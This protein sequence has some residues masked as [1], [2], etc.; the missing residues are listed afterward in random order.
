MPSYDLTLPGAGVVVRAPP[1]TLWLR[2]GAQSSRLGVS[3]PTLFLS[4]RDRFRAGDLA[5]FAAGKSEDGNHIL[6]ASTFF[7]EFETVRECLPT[8]MDGNEMRKALQ[9]EI[10]RNVFDQAALW[11]R[12]FGGTTFVLHVKGT[13]QPNTPALPEFLHCAA[14]IPPSFLANHPE[15]HA[16][17]AQIAQIF[18][19]SV[20]VPTV[21]DWT[22]RALARGWSLSMG[23]QTPA[24]NV[25]VSTLIPNPRTPGSAHLKFMGRAVGEL[26][27]ILHP[28]VIMIP[29]DDDDDYFDSA[30]HN[31]F[32]LADQLRCMQSLAEDRRQQIDVLEQRQAVLRARVATLESEVRQ[33]RAQYQIPTQPQSPS[34]ARTPATTA[35][36][37][38]PL[39]TNRSSAAPF[40][41]VRS[42]APPPYSA[43]SPL[44][45]RP[46]SSLAHR[47]TPTHAPLVDNSEVSALILQHGLQHL[48]A[49]VNLIQR[50]TQ[51]VH[52]YEELLQLGIQAGV[53]SELVAAMNTEDHV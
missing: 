38:S 51:P 52:W 53:A 17:I 25:N 5:W 48:T 44:S 20:G 21:Q 11:D 31:T 6:T 7:P 28:P 10:Q 35:T 18:L 42:R 9:E 41:P 4:F 1:H 29:D 2:G 13:T 45:A 3:Q 39:P 36:R 40:T 14:Y 43:A 24:R 47:S 12:S 30:D 49:S 46:M 32:D 37:S 34:R 22:A 8:G 16:P 27:A 23:G 33:F 15:S 19:E 26:D 50:S